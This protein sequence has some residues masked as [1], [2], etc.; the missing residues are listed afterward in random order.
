MEDNNTQITR[1]ILHEELKRTLAAL[2]NSSAPGP[3][4]ITYEI[5]KAL[6]EDNCASLLAYLNEYLQA[7]DLPNAWKKSK[8]WTIHKKGDKTCLNNYQPL[9]LCQMMYKLLTIIINK[10]LY[11]AVERWGIL[12]NTQSAFHWNRSTVINV[13]ML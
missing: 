11:E 3:D 8:I 9:A 1:P 6:D 10:R 13:V 4:E 2:P 7:S 12:L 5:I